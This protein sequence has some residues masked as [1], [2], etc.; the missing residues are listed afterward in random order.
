MP[1]DDPT[2]PLL[3]LVALTLVPVVLAAIHIAIPTARHTLALSHDDLTLVTVWSSAFVHVDSQHLLSNLTGYFLAVVPT[4]LLYVHWDR[5]R[6]FWHSILLALLV[7]PPVVNLGSNVYF[8]SQGVADGTV[9]RG[10]SGV[11]GAFAGMGLASVVAFVAEVYGLRRAYWLAQ[12]VVLAAGG[13]ILVGLVGRLE[14]LHAGLVGVGLLLSITGLVRAERHG[15]AS[16]RAHSTT[17]LV[18]GYTVGMSLVVVY[19]LFPSDVVTEGG[20]TNV[21]AHAT[22]VVVG[23]LLPGVARVVTGAK[24]LLE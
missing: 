17:L 15:L 16:L 9:S 7:V 12:A 13:V 23:S 14:P 24:V 19:L 2:G 20:V 10:F 8:T 3:E 21:V 6:L 22:G 18:L 1:R 4:Y 5:R 11:V